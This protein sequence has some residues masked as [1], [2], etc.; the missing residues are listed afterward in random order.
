[1]TGQPSITMLLEQ[2][3]ARARRSIVRK[4]LA[5]TPAALLFLLATAFALY[6]VFTSSAGALVGVIVF[7]LPAFALTYEA[8]AAL[9][10][11]RSSPRITRGV[12]ARMW[13]KGTVLWMTRAY[14]LLIESPAESSGSEQHFFVISPEAYLQLSDGRTVEVRHWPHTNTVVSLGVIESNAN[15]R[16]RRR[17]T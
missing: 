10:D 3:D 4:A 17:S 11:L 12:I 13:N 7:G 16:D 9:R 14:Y 1:M 15:T 8:V 6:N 5:F 2:P